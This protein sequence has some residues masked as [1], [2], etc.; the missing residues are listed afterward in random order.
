MAVELVHL[1]SLYH[2]DVIDEAA[3]RRTVESVNARW[4]NLTAI[5]AGDF[6]LAQASEI[7]ASLGTEVAGPA[8]RHHRP[9][10]RGRGARAATAFDVGRTEDAYFA[11][12]AGK[13]AALFA[14]ACRIG[15]I[16]AGLPR[17]RI[18]ALTAFGDD[19][20]MAFQIVD[21]VLDVVATEEELGK[22]AGHDLVEGVYTL[23]VL[24]TLAAPDGEGLRTM[25]GRPLDEHELDAAR[26]LVRSNGAVAASLDVA[27]AYAD[28]AVGRA[29]SAGPVR[30]RLVAGLDGLR[31]RRP[32]RPPNL[33]S[34]P[35]SSG[36]A[37]LSRSLGLR[38]GRC[39][40]PGQEVEHGPI[41]GAVCLHHDPVGCAADDPQFC[42]G[43]QLGDLLGVGDR[44]QDVL[45]A[46]EDQRRDGDLRRAPRSESS[47]SRMARTWPTNACDGADI[48]SGPSTPNAGEN[49]RND[50]EPTSQRTLAVA[51]DRMPSDSATSTHSSSSSRRQAVCRHAGAGEHQR[52][53][54]CGMV[55]RQELRQ[56]PT[57]RR[58]DD[59]GRVDPGGV[60]HGHGVVGHLIES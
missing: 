28:T 17:P 32:R 43:D 37:G 15:A 8:G 14:T 20:G 50:R 53:D 38:G 31:P 2:D 46:H 34:H 55:E 7:A 44:G 22:P 13:T 11:S 54:P 24:R 10:V 33:L 27:R 21:D 23:P 56:R 12:I 16:V 30:R 58:T 9:A 29:R 5:L 19:Y 26:S 39:R 3:T 48:A 49:R 40:D 36:S 51:N 52:A 60:E 42:T 25:L 57:H 47:K 1:G 59:V 35:G 4:G 6:L 45:A 18:D 41:E